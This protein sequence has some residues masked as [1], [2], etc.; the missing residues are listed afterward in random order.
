MK[1]HKK[2]LASLPILVSILATQACAAENQGETVNILVPHNKFN[3]T[4]V[5]DVFIN[6]HGP[7]PFAIDTGATNSS[8]SKRLATELGLVISTQNTRETFTV[9]ELVFYDYTDLISLKIGGDDVVRN[10]RLNVID[11]PPN[12]K[13]NPLGIIGAT[14]L[15][16]GTLENDSKSNLLKLKLPKERPLCDFIDESSSCYDGSDYLQLKSFSIG[17]A[18]GDLVIDTGYSGDDS[19]LLFKSNFTNDLWRNELGAISEEKSILTKSGTVKKFR[20]KDFD[21]HGQQNCST[22][23]IVQSPKNNT[24]FFSKVTGTLGWSALKNTDFKIDYSDKIS[25]FIPQDFCPWN[26][27]RTLGISA[28]AF[29]HD[30]T[31]MQIAS[32][33]S[34]SPADKAG[35]EVGDI[36]LKVILENG[37]VIEKFNNDIFEY[38]DIHI[39]AEPGTKVVYVLEGENPPKK[40]SIIA[41]NET[42][43]KIDSKASGV[44]L[45]KKKKLS[46]AE[47]FGDK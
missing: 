38:D 15:L 28:V 1:K 20:T 17:T 8:I 19:I 26:R 34:G 14:E 22:K 12:N 43:I 30:Q 45:R 3:R 39:Y 13:T 40:V 24:P 25:S 16:G 41:E 10:T 37:V 9:N 29:A 44:K 31:V 7:Y 2:I 36:V 18:V 23:V 47:L 27:E 46:A 21:I 35:L 4:P 11:L 32:I 33:I 42:H 5:V 6:D